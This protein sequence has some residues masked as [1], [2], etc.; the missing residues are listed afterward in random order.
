MESVRQI[1]SIVHTEF[2]L[3]DRDDPGLWSER[4]T[5]ANEK[6]AS[7]PV[8]VF[9]MYSTYIGCIMALE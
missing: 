6:F 3:D 7:F 4:R 9:G 2:L 1:F 5:I 8:G